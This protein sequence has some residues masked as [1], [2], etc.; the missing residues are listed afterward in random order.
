MDI[1]YDSLFVANPAEHQTTSVVDLCK[2]HDTTNSRLKVGS[3][4]YY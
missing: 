4:R 3:P 1:T 2:A